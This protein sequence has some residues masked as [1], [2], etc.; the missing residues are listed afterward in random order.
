MVTEFGRSAYGE[1][2][3]SGDEC[4]ER[5]P[6]LGALLDFLR[7]VGRGETG[8]GWIEGLRGAGK[9]ELIHRAVSCHLS[10]E[11]SAVFIHYPLQPYRLELFD[12]A[13]SY[14]TTFVRQYR[15]GFHGEE[16]NL[17]ECVDA[18]HSGAPQCKNCS[19]ASL[20]EMCEA[21]GRAYLQRDPTE[22][23]LLMVN[24]PHYL[25]ELQGR[26]CVLIFDHA[27]YL[28]QVHHRGH[29]V[30]LLRHLA[31]HLGSSAAPVFLVD[32][33]PGL[34]ALLG[35][36]AANDRLGACE[37]ARL[38]PQDALA[39][40][41]TLCDQLGVSMS[42]RLVEKHLTQLGGLPLYLH[43][44][45]RRAH[46]A[47]LALDSTER[48]GQVY[49]QEIRDGTI[50]WYWRAQFSTQ[51]PQAVERQQA[52][53]L[54]SHLAGFW[55][56]RASLTALSQNL[57]LD[58]ARL[59]D[60]LNRLQLMGVADRSFGTVSLVDDP[61]LR[62][63]VTVLAWGESS[64]TSDAELLRRLAARRVRVAS[65]PPIE[66]TV[67]EFLV[68]LERLLELF[69]GQYLPAEWFH[70]HEEYSAVWDQANHPRNGLSETMVRLP[71]LM[72]VSRMDLAASEVLADRPIVVCGM[73]FRDRQLTPGNE[74]LWM[75]VIW[76]RTQALAAEQV[77]ETLR[78]KAAVQEKTGREVAYTW[79]I[80][81]GGFTRQAR[82]QCAQG[83][84]MTG[85]MDM[86]DFVYDQ[87]F[88][89]DS[90][91]R[92]AAERSPAAPDMIVVQPPPPKTLRREIGMFLSAGSAPRQAAL[93]GFEEVARE[94][95][96]P[97]TRIG[98]MR[99]AIFEAVIRCAETATD[100]SDTIQVHCEA[101]P[102]QIEI[103]VRSHA[104][105][106]SAPADGTSQG[107]GV[108]C[109]FAD[110]AKIQALEDGTEIHLTYRHG[111]EAGEREKAADSSA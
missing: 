57:S 41:Q 49:A 84:L 96:F 69:R 7:R 108:I 60:L 89:R 71:Y 17:Q 11:P 40:L 99:L 93:E 4:Y 79:L 90:P 62:D 12:L 21:M 37:I 42:V 97:P 59:Q 55:P 104:Q 98:Q 1:P 23:L 50:H 34:R 25:S 14:Y 39:M 101:Q 38:D 52:A 54:C 51:F 20:R 100:P 47:G 73:G 76:P 27:R 22:M 81:R 36:L 16:A 80:S 103:Y 15:Y 53:D 6:Q 30:P 88:A 5:A 56:H 85:N 2:I 3:L 24:M 109:S 78:L 43:S 102:G 28:R 91:W 58:P 110:G 46:V 66:E 26:R 32:S 105:G 61:V 87:M 72:A 111:M 86:V 8:G 95:G 67:G 74:T 68:R 35:D 63:V 48:F 45:V 10:A 70:Y 29:A 9:T 82:Q 33:A 18:W 77:Q 92:E 19:E 107:L 64:S 106:P 65:T 75:T 44:M 83:R 94:M 13:R 31:A